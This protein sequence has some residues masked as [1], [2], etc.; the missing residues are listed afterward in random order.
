MCRCILL[1]LL[2]E[3]I[4]LILLIHRFIFAK[5]FSS[6]SKKKGLATPFIL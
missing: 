5:G 1:L 2:F 6:K 4:L 3:E